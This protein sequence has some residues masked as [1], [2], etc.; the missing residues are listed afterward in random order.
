VSTPRK[1]VDNDAH[2]R[3]QIDGRNRRKSPQTVRYKI[4][5]KIP[6]KIMK[7]KNIAARGRI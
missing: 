7:K 6:L 5:L 1:E 3:T 2:P 4:G